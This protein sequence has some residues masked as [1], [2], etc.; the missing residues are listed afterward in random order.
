MRATDRQSARP[1]LRIK[2]TVRS[3]WDDEDIADVA[4]CLAGIAETVD[5]VQRCAGSDSDYEAPPT[6]PPEVPTHAWAEATLARFA[7]GNVVTGE[8]KAKYIVFFLMLNWAA[9]VIRGSKF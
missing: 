7:M 5:N 4:L 9:R 3:S 8:T 1:D 6:I 2:L